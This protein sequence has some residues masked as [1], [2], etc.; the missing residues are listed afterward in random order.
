MSQQAFFQMLA[1]PIAIVAVWEMKKRKTRIRDMIFIFK[2]LTVSPGQKERKS[3]QHKRTQY[4]CSALRYWLIL[5]AAGIW[6]GGS[7]AGWYSWKGWDLTFSLQSWERIWLYREDKGLS[8]RGH[9]VT[10]W[11]LWGDWPDTWNSPEFPIWAYLFFKRAAWCEQVG[12]WGCVWKEMGFKFQ[13]WY[14]LAVRPEA[15][16]LTFLSKSILY[17]FQA[18]IKLIGCKIMTC[19]IILKWLLIMYLILVSYKGKKC[20]I[21]EQFFL[22]LYKSKLWTVFLNC[23]APY[24]GELQL[25]LSRQH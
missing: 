19:I 21:C 2:G 5:N 15:G 3:W 1:L 17:P 24:R 14:W 12:A 7:T 8:G 23:K 18:V 20:C 10:S 9:C 6:A 4:E 13:L 11:D 25:P 22:F 16:P